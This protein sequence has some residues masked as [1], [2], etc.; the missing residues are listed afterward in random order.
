MLGGGK[1][2]TRKGGAEGGE[3]QGKEEEARKGGEGVLAPGKLTA[4]RRG[5]Y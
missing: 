5:V 4:T 2:G 3:Q 1:G